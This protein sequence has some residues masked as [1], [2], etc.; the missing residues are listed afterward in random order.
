M[1][2]KTYRLFR[3]ISFMQLQLNGLS[4]PRLPRLDF[5]R[6]EIWRVI[7]SLCLIPDRLLARFNRYCATLA[8][9]TTGLAAATG[10]ANFAGSIATFGWT[11]FSVYMDCPSV[12]VKRH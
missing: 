4:S 5:I 1:R 6:A 3:S 7:E 8:G 10:L 2:M 12:H 11:S 9:A